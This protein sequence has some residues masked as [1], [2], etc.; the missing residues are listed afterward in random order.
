VEP[1]P[2]QFAMPLARGAGRGSS[3]SLLAVVS[4]MALSPAAPGL[5]RWGLQTDPAAGVPGAGSTASLRNRRV[6][7]TVDPT[8]PVRPTCRG[9]SATKD[10]AAR[11]PRTR[12]QHELQRKPAPLREVRLW[13]QVRESLCALSPGTKLD[14]SMSGGVTVYGLQGAGSYRGTLSQAW[15][16]AR[17]RRLVPRLHGRQLPIR[18][19]VSIRSDGS[20]SVTFL[21]QRQPEPECPGGHRGTITWNCQDVRINLN[22]YSLNAY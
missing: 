19:R 12:G 7:A 13:R 15:S 11:S 6:P 20:G 17:R 2:T 9:P 10:R 16:L 8:A 14:R 3:L 4:L 1:N 22:A 21:R 5:R 18:N